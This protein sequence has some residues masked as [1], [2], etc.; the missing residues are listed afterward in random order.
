MLK[1]NIFLVIRQIRK[2]PWYSFVNLLGLSI[3][4]GCSVLIFLWVK[5]ELGYDRF[6]PGADRI[7]RVTTD[8]RLSSGQHQALAV[9][10]APLAKALKEEYPEVLA[11]TR[12]VVAGNTLV[13]RGDRSFFENQVVI[14]DPGFW[15]VFAL[16][17]A[18]GDPAGVLKEPNSLLLTRDM[19]RKYFGDEDPLGQT[20]R[21][22]NQ[23]ECRVTGILENLPDNSQFH[24]QFL[25]RPGGN[26]PLEETRW[27]A[28]SVYTYVRLG[29]GA[30]AERLE[31]KIQDLA[32]KYGGP[33][34][35]ETFTFRLQ[36]FTSI[37]LHSDR[38]ADFAPVMSLNQIYLLSTVAV[39]VLGVACVNFI[40]LSIA[41]SGRRARE[42][43][44]RKT[45]GAYRGRLI[46][47][48][49]AESILS[50]AAAFGLAL[51]LV[52]L[53]LP[54]FNR[55]AGTS[56]RLDL[57]ANLI[58]LAGLV[59]VVGVL[60]GGYP[61][62]VLSAFR[63]SEVF[64]GKGQKG[65]SGLFLRKALIVFQ[66]AAS[67]GL[68]V[69]TGVVSRQM[70]FVR[71]ANLGYDQEQ[72]LSIRLRSPEV[73]RGTE[74]LKREFLQ[75]PGI[76][77]AT[78]GSTLP[79]YGAGRRGYF[80]EGAE[81][82]SIMIATMSVDDDFISTM[83]MTLVAGRGFSREFPSDADASLIINE[84]AQ[85][86]FGWTE[87]VGRKFEEVTMREGQREILTRTV[88]GVVKDFHL[89]SLH[90]KI[91]PVVLRV[92]PQNFQRLNLKLRPGN[93]EETLAFVE[94][95]MRQV[96]P[97]FPPEFE[98]LDA[99]YERWYRND[100]RLGQIF[101][102]FSLITIFVACLGL[103]GLAAYIAE[104]RT[105]E[106]GIRK[107]LGATNGSLVRLLTTEFAKWVLLANLIA[108]PAAYAAMRNWLGSFSYRT[109][110]HPGIMILSGLAALAIA[111]AT[112]GV[113]AFRAAAADPTTSIRHE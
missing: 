111:L 112:V 4:L 82:R 95:K 63:P 41:R 17:P 18:V 35:R 13:R 90:D 76:I 9:S 96:Q 25:I 2:N 97:E 67:I 113:Q 71:S 44:M 33:R 69:A 107:V 38:E 32:E 5:N 58:F 73:I 94:T 70:S 20:L 49:L 77:G 64:R 101:A 48:F 60:A 56:L 8:V 75:N 36:P 21:L 53:F 92:E 83:G 7:F 40:N 52:N 12:L 84:T 81:E 110:I 62:M 88:V 30:G 43:G 85:A 14:T 86:R 6:F 39:L 26:G 108:W 46:R 105:K 34:G 91:E 66:F 50:T 27:N 15:D 109:S 65:T 42:V 16:R 59:V 93:L 68:F 100:R 22:N 80:P 31:A 72:I 74:G 19:A 57:G 29:K 11:A 89:R 28:L 23:T 51:I 3:G 55:L 98:F 79:V 1:S 47:Q 54:I 24:V 104:L 37:H 78:A 99:A 106:I 10:A 87:A 45:L 103:F 61:A 102:C